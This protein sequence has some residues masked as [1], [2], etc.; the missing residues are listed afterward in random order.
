MVQFT[1]GI[2][3][4]RQEPPNTACTRPLEEHPDYSGGTAA[5]QCARFQAA[6]V[7]WSG[8]R[9]SGVVPSRPV[10]EPVETHQCPDDARRW[11]NKCKGYRFV[12]PDFQALQ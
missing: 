5:S 6:C 4:G 1:S 3:Q 10:V 2:E 8:F 12:F 11:A 9:Q 7:A